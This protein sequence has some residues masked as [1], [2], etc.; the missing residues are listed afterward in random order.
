MIGEQVLLARFARVDRKKDG[1]WLVTCPAHAD[2][3]PSLHVSRADDRW[4]IRCFAGCSYDA[5]IAAA[6][7]SASDL[8]ENGNGHRPSGPSENREAIATY[9]YTDEAGTLLY[10]VLRFPGKQF[11]QRRPDGRGGWEL[12]LG[13]TRRVLYR[14]PAVIAAVAAGRVVHVVEGEE[15]VHALERAGAVA[16]TNSGGALKW[17]DE[18]SRVLAGARV[19]V[20]ADRDEPGRRHAEMVQVSLERIGA[21]VTVVEP[22]EGKDARDH[23]TAGRGLDE[24]VPVGGGSFPGGP[25]TAPALRDRGDAAATSWTPVDLASALD[26]TAAD[27]APTVLARSDGV[28]LMYPGRRHLVMGEPEACKGWMML[29]ASTQILAEGGRVL[30]VD[31]EDSAAS[32]VGRLLALGVDPDAI[33]DRLLYVRPDAAI[34]SRDRDLILELAPTIQL[35]VFDGV[36]E[37]MVLHGLDLNSNTDVATWAERLSKPLARAGVP[38]VEIDHVVKDKEARGRYAIGAQ[39]KLAGVDVAYSLEVVEPFGRGRDGKVKVVIKKDRPGHVRGHADDRDVAAFIHLTSS[40]SGGVSVS[41][42]APDSEQPA[43]AAFRPTGLMEK[44]SKVLEGEPGMTRNELRASVGGRAKYVD[45][46][47]QILVTEGYVEVRQDGQAHRHHAIRIYRETDDR[48]PGSQPGPNWVPDPVMGTGSPGPSPYRGDPVPDPVPPP[49]ENAYRVPGPVPARDENDEA[50][51][52]PGSSGDLVA[53]G[54]PGL[55]GSPYDIDNLE[56]A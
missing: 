7:L 38:V 14:L 35:A 55:H 29:A 25:E 20:V 10:E 22:V 50:D 9:P 39:H 19:T 40:P 17:R 8:M 30:Y 45:L 33:R 4:L 56:A 3:T 6:G 41:L 36:T 46:A 31:F 16:T 44:M 12:R 23:L 27:A 18:Y 52:L 32:V 47:R 43:A 13:D 51:R 11:R 34:T 42:S 53:T 5:V 54:R 1:D 2:R 28:A 49:R 24:F 21:T 26:G 15:D 48:V 37:A